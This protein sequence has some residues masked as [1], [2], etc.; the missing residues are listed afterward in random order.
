[1]IQNKLSSILVASLLAATQLTVQAQTPAGAGAA[2]NAAMGGV[3]TNVMIATAAGVAVIASLSSGNSGSFGAA[4]VATSEGAKSSAAAATNAA[5]AN[6][7]ISTGLTQLQAALVTAGLS[8][9]ADISYA[10]TQADLAAKAAVTAAAAAAQAA[11]DLAVA[12]NVAIVGVVN[13]GRTIC[14]AANSCTKAEI[15]VLG[16]NAAVLAQK[17][18]DATNFAVLVAQALKDVVLSK[19]ANFPISTFNTW[20]AD[21]KAAAVKA[22]AS[23]DQ[24]E[25]D[26][27]KAAAAL[28][29]TGTTIAVGPTGTTGTTGTSGTTGT[30]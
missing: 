24:A 9:N 5:T 17:A 27:N 1:M 30:L 6:T 28:G 21:A 13:G 25:S 20:V 7:A 14:A 8:T 16:L 10:Y 18:V 15:L 2:T 22:Q 3:S 29:A 11:S 23:A 4:N 12:S 26:Y 19:S